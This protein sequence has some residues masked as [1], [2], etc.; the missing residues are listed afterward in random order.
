VKTETRKYTIKKGEIRMIIVGTQSE[1]FPNFTED[2]GSIFDDTLQWQLIP[3]TGASITGDIHVNDRHEDWLADRING[4]TLHG[5]GTA[6]I[7]EVKTIQ[8]PD[9]A[10]V[11][12][13]ITLKA[14]N[15]SDG[16]YPSRVIV[17]LVPIKLEKMWETKNQANQI[18]NPCRKDDPILPISPAPD[19]AGSVHGTNT[20][21]LYVSQD[22]SDGKYGISIDIGLD[23]IRTKIVAGAYSGSAKIAASDKFFPASGPLE[24]RVVSETDFTIRVGYDKNSNSILDAQEEIQI[25]TPATFDKS[26]KGEPTVRIISPE[27]YSSMQA[28]A[29]LI[30]S[31]AGTIPHASE[32]L[33]L[34][35]N[36]VAAG[37]PVDK[38]PTSADLIIFDAFKGEY[39]EW[40]THN[41]GALFSNDGFSGVPFYHWD[42]TTS[43]SEMAGLSYT[44]KSAVQTHFKTTILPQVVTYFEN[45]PFNSIANFPLDGVSTVVQNHE[46]TPAW[47]KK[48][49]VTFDD[50]ILPN[51][52]GDDAFGVIGR[53]RVT[54]HEARYKVRKVQITEYVGDDAIGGPRFTESTG[55]EVE[56]RTV[57]CVEDLYD[58]NFNAGFINKIGAALQIGYGNGTYGR[59][60]GRIFRWD[61][62]W[63]E[64]FEWI[65]K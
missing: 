55:Y 47:V 50:P 16:E 22:P 53:G 31:S 26:T 18:F 9:D 23:E 1:E 27:T 58:F 13:T 46:S 7:E 4:V 17:G 30:I 42:S 44:T 64:T 21:D 3:S 45:L 24:F 57:G 19:A 65:E 59:F 36:G 5:I 28:A 43:A 12:V 29:A 63:D 2:E 52:G 54:S 15:I 48:T 32:F 20:N 8:A 56:A 11:T 14:T 35:Q 40:L 6:H 60:A 41:S 37:M 62:N 38:R 39:S 51:F 34:F 61:I 33:R 10:D 25:S 49:T